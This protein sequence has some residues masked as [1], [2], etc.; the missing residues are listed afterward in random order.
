MSEQE[1][2]QKPAFDKFMERYPLHFLESR[3][4]IAFYSSSSR[5]GFTSVLSTVSLSFIAIAIA[6]YAVYMAESGGCV[7]FAF[8]IAVAV[9]GLLGMVAIGIMSVYF[10]RNQNEPD[11]DLFIRGIMKG[12]IYK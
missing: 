5:W 10:M 12:Y 7:M 3:F 8:I 2:K 9:I 4:S 11:I 1:K 6:L